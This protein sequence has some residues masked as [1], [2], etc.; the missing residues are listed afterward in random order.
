MILKNNYKR[1]VHHLYV[2]NIQTKDASGKA[3]GTASV[4]LN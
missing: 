4:K 3:K 1:I 2:Q